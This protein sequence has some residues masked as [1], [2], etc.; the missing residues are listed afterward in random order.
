MQYPIV[1]EW[2]DENTAIGV[3]VPDIPGAI[4]AADTIEAA[5]I[6]AVEVAHIQLEALSEANQEIPVARSI[7]QHRKNPDYSGW[8]W[9]FID[10]DVTPYLG[11]SEK[12]NVTL[13]GNVIRQIDQYVNRH[14]AKSRSGF[15][16]AA[17]LEKLHRTVEKID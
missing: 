8:G 9:G 3:V 12:I 15:L 5:Y 17:A 7:E 16:A 11:K 4:T 1:I 14:K 6:A 13:P 10:L 2:G